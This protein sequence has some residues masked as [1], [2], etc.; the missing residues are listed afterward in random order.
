MW[1]VNLQ[2][3]L[4]YFLINYIVSFNVHKKRDGYC[5]YL[6]YRL[7][8]SILEWA[9]KAYASSGEFM[10]YLPTHVVF[11]KHNWHETYIMQRRAFQVAVGKVPRDTLQVDMPKPAFVDS[12]DDYPVD[13]EK[14]KFDPAKSHIYQF[15][16]AENGEPFEELF[17]FDPE[18]DSEP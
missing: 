12:K 17:L 18:V 5:I 13:P 9:S 6:A 11:G 14:F 3:L 15:D 10:K 4:K 1:V 8:Y 16:Y 2:G 7:A